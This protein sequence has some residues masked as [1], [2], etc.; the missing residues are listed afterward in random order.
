MPLSV[1][2]AVRG[3]SLKDLPVSAHLES[4]LRGLG[5]E[6]LGQLHGL[7]VREL[8]VRPNCGGKALAELATLLRRAEAGEFTLADQQLEKSTA[9]DLLGLLDDLASQLPDRDR[10][11]LLLHFGADGDAPKPFR[12]IGK[13]YG[14]SGSAIEQAETRS[15]ERIRRR[16]SAKLRNL[17][18]HILAPCRGEVPL[19]PAL[20]ATWIDPT[21]PPRYDLQFYLRIIAKLRSDLGMSGVERR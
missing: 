5:I 1:T 19:S 11:C 7:S 10:Q 15:L 20:L 16:G 12:Q 3:L 21:H 4:V 13:R 2:H 9:A 14:V 18:T 8:L 6:R 17:L